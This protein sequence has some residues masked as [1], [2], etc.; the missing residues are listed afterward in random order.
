VFAT[1]HLWLT[2][3]S[4]TVQGLQWLASALKNFIHPSLGRV[5]N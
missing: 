1:L 2:A 4:Q 5:R 3:L